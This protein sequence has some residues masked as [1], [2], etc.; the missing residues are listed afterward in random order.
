MIVNTYISLRAKAFYALPFYY[1][2]S[3][4]W[5]DGVGVVKE[6]LVIGVLGV[7]ESWVIHDRSPLCHCQHF[8]GQQ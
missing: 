4:S 3:F 8:C 6:A 5:I 2:A 1:S 7:T